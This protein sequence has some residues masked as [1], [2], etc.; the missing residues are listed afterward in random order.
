MQRL[1]A[2]LLA[3]EAS[4]R[5]GGADAGLIEVCGTAEWQRDGE[6]EGACAVEEQGAAA[7]EV[8]GGG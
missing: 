1:G 7:L 6:A 8:L 4:R 3:W 2:Q 5:G